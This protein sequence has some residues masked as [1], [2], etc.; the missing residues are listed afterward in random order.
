MN[1]HRKKL[2]A[3]FEKATTGRTNL[4]EMERRKL[5]E[6]G[7]EYRRVKEASDNRCDAFLGYGK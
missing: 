7:F 1:P 5:E 3:I 6:S 2:V 4:M